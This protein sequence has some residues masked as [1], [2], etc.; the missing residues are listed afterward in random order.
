MSS[1]VYQ[2]DNFLFA[3]SEAVGGKMWTSEEKC[4]SSQLRLENNFL[5]WY[6]KVWHGMVWYS[7]VYHTWFG[8]IWYG[9]T[10]Y[11]MV[12]FGVIWYA[13]TKYGLVIPASPKNHL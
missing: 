3:P 2:R 9:I 12:W 6:N 13:I 10:K 11:G 8:M 4:W 1:L 7:M 5:V